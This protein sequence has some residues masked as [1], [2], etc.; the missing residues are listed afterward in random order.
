MRASLPVQYGLNRS[1]ARLNYEFSTPSGPNAQ[2]AVAAANRLSFR[3]PAVKKP[4]RMGIVGNV[5]VGEPVP[6]PAA[7]HILIGQFDS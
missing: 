3:P 6:V 2:F 4:N 1:I 5:P 7:R